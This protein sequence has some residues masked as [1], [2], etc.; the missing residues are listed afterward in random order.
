VFFGGREEVI[1]DWVDLF[2]LEHRD[3][4]QEID[5]YKLPF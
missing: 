4:L 5:K 2:E 1:E 3:E